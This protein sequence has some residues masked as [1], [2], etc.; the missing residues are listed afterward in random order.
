MRRLAGQLTGTLEPCCQAAVASRRWARSRGGAKKSR[1]TDDILPQELFTPSSAA[2]SLRQAT[3]SAS[4]AFATANTPSISSMRAEIESM[5]KEKYF[6]EVIRKEQQAKARTMKAVGSQ[7]QQRRGGQG[8][9]STATILPAVAPSYNVTEGVVGDALKAN[10]W[11]VGR[12][13][14][15]D[16][17]DVLRPKTQRPGSSNSTSHRDG[18]R[19]AELSGVLRAPTLSAANTTVVNDLARRVRDA[20]KRYAP[21]MELSDVSLRDPLYTAALVDVVQSAPENDLREW[22]RLG[23]IDPLWWSDDADAPYPVTNNSSTATAL[24]AE[25]LEDNV[26]DDLDPLQAALLAGSCSAFVG[27]ASE[28]LTFGDVPPPDIAPAIL[29]AE[30]GDFGSVSEKELRA[31][32]LFETQSGAGQ[33]LTRSLSPSSPLLAALAKRDDNIK[34]SVEVLERVKRETLLDKQFQEAVEHVNVLHE[35]RVA[36]ME[37]LRPNPRPVAASMPY[38]FGSPRSRPPP[39]ADMNLPAPALS[40]AERTS[41]RRKRKLKVL[42]QRFSS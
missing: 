23:L 16:V 12:R 29:K 32:E 11:L 14:Q 17:A 20:L 36:S 7:L 37:K 35:G 40:Q 42:R 15:R 30:R 38:F 13:I 34:K 39:A 18:M 28:R 22:L 8:A 24:A 41:I 1:Q 25:H 4:A 27:A 33:A 26:A 10:E 2:P 6:E 31:L 19:L 21:Q 3:A 5:R 9:A